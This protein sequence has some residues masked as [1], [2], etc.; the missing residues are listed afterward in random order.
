MFLFMLLYPSNKINGRSGLNA[1]DHPFNLLC[2][3]KL[4]V[5]I[6]IVYL[7]LPVDVFISTAVIWPPRIFANAN[8]S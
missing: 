2:L 3:I 4:S 8:A 1:Y 5:F 6:P 7:A